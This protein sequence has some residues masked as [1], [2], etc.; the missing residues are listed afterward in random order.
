MIELDQICLWVAGYP[1]HD[2]DESLCVPDFSCCIPA[3]LVPRETREAYLAAY[4]R[5]FDEDPRRAADALTAIERMNLRFLH[6][7][8]A[9]VGAWVAN[10]QGGLQGWVKK[11]T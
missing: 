1:V 8:V 3:L 9:G 11:R 5:Q 7:R 4:M 6:L 10:E 2:D